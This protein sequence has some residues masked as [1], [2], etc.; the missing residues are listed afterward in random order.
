MS[1]KRLNTEDMLSE[2][3]GQS[4]FFPATQPKPSQFVSDPPKRVE[5][6]PAQASSSETNQPS[7]RDTLVSRYHDTNLETIRK[8][9]RQ[10]GKEAATHRF[11][12]DEK[13][14]LTE[15]IFAYAKQGI[16]TN[17]NE[18]TRIAINLLFEDHKAN[19]KQSILDKAL[20]L[21]NN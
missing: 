12:V 7:N 5:P 10:F 11:T 15:L 4:A 19:G 3:K 14:R 16:R 21:L 9:V 17:E 1:K 2:L 13:Q 6:A 8:A 20:R 18:I